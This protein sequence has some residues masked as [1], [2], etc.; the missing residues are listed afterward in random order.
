MFIVKQYGAIST[1]YL[2]INS[3]EM[4]NILSTTDGCSDGQKNSLNDVQK[5]YLKE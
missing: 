5:E 2:F 4:N 1:L 3:V